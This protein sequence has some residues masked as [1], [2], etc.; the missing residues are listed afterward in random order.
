[1]SGEEWPLDDTRVLGAEV[2]AGLKPF[3]LSQVRGPRGQLPVFYSGVLPM[4]MET[5]LLRG[6]CA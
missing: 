3:V 6:L 5:A 1:M 4:K 2:T